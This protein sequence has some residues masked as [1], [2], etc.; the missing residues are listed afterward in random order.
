MFKLFYLYLINYET[1][2]CFIFKIIIFVLSG[3]AM[4]DAV[5][6]NSPTELDGCTGVYNV[7]W[8]V[9]LHNTVVSS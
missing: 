2:D 1:F 3:L 5:F 6:I 8:W 4:Q 9:D 7:A